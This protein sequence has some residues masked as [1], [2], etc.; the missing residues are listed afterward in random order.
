MKVPNTHT[1][2]QEAYEDNQY[3]FP[4]ICKNNAVMDVYE[5]G[6]KSPN[7][8]STTGSIDG[9]C[10]SDEEGYAEIQ[11]KKPRKNFKSKAERMEFVSSFKK[12]QKTELCKNWQEFGK[13]KY[14]DQCSFAHGIAELRVR[15]DMPSTYKTK[16]CKFFQEQSICPYGVRCQFIHTHLTPEKQ[17]TSSYVKMLQTNAGYME[18]RLKCFENESCLLEESP[19]FSYVSAYDRKRLSIFTEL[20]SN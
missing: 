16:Q 12:K 2:P 10:P 3:Y 9:K 17:K 4:K 6:I 5:D 18:A 14:K 13:C 8:N 1:P 15:N 19:N 11:Y 7:S 20:A